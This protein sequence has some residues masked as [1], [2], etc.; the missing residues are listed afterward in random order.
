VGYGVLLALLD[1][2]LELLQGRHCGIWGRK[3]GYDEMLVVCS[4]T[5]SLSRCGLVPIAEELGSMMQDSRMKMA[6]SRIPRYNNMLP[7]REDARIL[8]YVD[9]AWPCHMLRSATVA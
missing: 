5:C 6:K 9:I 2:G 7:M 3:M 4:L 1:F 8:K